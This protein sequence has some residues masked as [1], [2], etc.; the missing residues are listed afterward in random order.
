MES[1]VQQ[2][3]VAAPPLLLF[4]CCTQTKATLEQCTS[5]PVPTLYP[6]L[7]QTHSFDP[8]QLTPH[9]AGV[10]CQDD[11]DSKS[12]EAKLCEDKSAGEL[13]RL[14]GGSDACRD[15]IQCTAAVS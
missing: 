4:P 14:K 11:E 8:S 6:N 2:L 10:L 7:Q 9:L 3:S 13:F 5:Q 15:V 12:H 1:C